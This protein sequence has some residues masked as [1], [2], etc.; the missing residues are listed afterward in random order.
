MWWDGTVGGSSSIQMELGVRRR[1][2]K[3]VVAESA[4]TRSASMPAEVGDEIGG[5]DGGK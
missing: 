3:R 5:F 2:V 1:M 4:C